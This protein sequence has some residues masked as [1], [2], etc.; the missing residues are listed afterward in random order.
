MIRRIRRW[1]A[2]RDLEDQLGYA[3]SQFAL[4]KAS[5]NEKRASRLQ[6]VIDDLRNQIA[7]L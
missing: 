2:R 6:T 5:L 1:L 7:S 4:A 3:G